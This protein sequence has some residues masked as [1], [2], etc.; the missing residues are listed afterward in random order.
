MKFIS[1]TAA[2]GTLPRETQIRTDKAL[3][4]WVKPRGQLSIPRLIA[5]SIFELIDSPRHVP[6]QGAKVVL[7]Y[8]LDL[9]N[10]AALVLIRVLFSL[11]RQESSFVIF[12]HHFETGLPQRA[13]AQN[14][15]SLA[16]GYAI[17]AQSNLSLLV[18]RRLVNAIMVNRP[19]VSDIQAHLSRLTKSISLIGV[20]CG[21]DLDL[22]DATGAG[23]RDRSIVVVG[24]LRTAKGSSLLAETTKHLI[25][26]GQDSRLTIVG[27]H[28][29]EA[30]REFLSQLPTQG[31]V[32]FLENLSDTE[33]IEVLKASKVFFSPSL[34][35][36]W[37]LSLDEAVA[38]G[39]LC[40]VFQLP[41][42]ERYW[43]HPRVLQV[44]V[45][46]GALGLATKIR[47]ALKAGTD[48]QAQ[49]R[50]QTPYPKDVKQVAD[51]YL[52]IFTEV[53]GGKFVTTS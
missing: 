23:S 15:Q 29:V 49:W 53:T 27:R 17:M 28:T 40:V 30:K 37:S 36:G 6:R 39:L 2:Q 9:L 3:P 52:R 50:V 44:P 5:C 45:T 47:E 41:A 19:I 21:V 8:N 24:G 14:F 43:D 10:V 46:D 38:S 12:I 25:D 20:D 35:E 48:K 26:L 32:E 34:E 42:Y 13:A 11:R 31:D 16:R 18:A 33:V 1:A 4:R 51:E 7:V 22:I